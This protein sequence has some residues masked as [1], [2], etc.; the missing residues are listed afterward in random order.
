MSR[1]IS[2]NEASTLTGK[3]K[4][5]IRRAV[6]ANKN[7]K[8]V[9]LE[10]TGYLISADWI[11]AQ[12]K[13]EP[14]T[15]DDSPAEDST[16]PTGVHKDSISDLYG[17]LAKELEAKDR[18]I[19]ELLSQLK[20]KEENTTKLQ[21][22]FQQL[23]AVNQLPATATI[24]DNETKPKTT[25]T[26]RKTPTKAK[27]KV[28]T[29]SVDLNLD[30]ESDEFLDLK[31]NDK[32]TKATRVKPKATVTKKKPAGKKKPVSKKAPVKKRRWYQF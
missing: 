13:L 31:V 4:D 6:K 15:P 28:D 3:H 21:D 11:L 32:T 26:K 5:T 2:I 23:L 22:Q 24:L 20:Q 17:V 12:Y 10:S 7:T 18:T 27:A 25:G 9:R 19:S 29:V 14:E 30:P 16:E 1:Y 8:Y